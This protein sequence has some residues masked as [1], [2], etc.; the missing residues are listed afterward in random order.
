MQLVKN[1]KKIIIIDYAHTPDALNKTINE[2]KSFYNKEVNL[3]F[4]CGGDRDKGKRSVMGKI[5]QK[6]CKKVYITDDNPRYENPAHIRNEIKKNCSKGIVIPSRKNAIKKA[7]SE[8]KQEILIIAGKGHEN[9]QI[10]KN[11]KIN[12]SD[13]KF[14]NQ[15]SK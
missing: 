15:Y 5:A 6:L 14:A 8:L 13:Y 1:K 9:Y 10:V 4:G 7:I 12:F 11:K 2:A 3:L